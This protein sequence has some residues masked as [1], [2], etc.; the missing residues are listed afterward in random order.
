MYCQVHASNIHLSHGQEMIIPWESST[1]NNHHTKL[2]YIKVF[3]DS[4]YMI[5]YDIKWKSVGNTTQPLCLTIYK[6]TRDY[7]LEPLNRHVTVYVGNPI[8][9]HKKWDA[10][11]LNQERVCIGAKNFSTCEFILMDLKFSLC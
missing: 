7:F 4:S 2:E 10:H 9:V 1:R 3:E 5:N 8:T 11:L 6:V